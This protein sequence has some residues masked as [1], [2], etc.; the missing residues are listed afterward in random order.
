MPRSGQQETHFGG[1]CPLQGYPVRNVF[2]FKPH[3][4]GFVAAVLGNGRTACTLS[5][6]GRLPWPQRGPAPHRCPRTS[7]FVTTSALQAHTPQ[8]DNPA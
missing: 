6:R 1:F 7:S 8:P 2:C 3:V 4:W 5:S